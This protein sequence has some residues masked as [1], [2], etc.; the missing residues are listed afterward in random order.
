VFVQ[1]YAAVL[2]IDPAIERKIGQ[3]DHGSLTADQ[4]RQAVLLGAHTEAR[5]DD[6]P[7]HGE[8]WI[9]R[10]KSYDG[11]ELIAYVMPANQTD[12]GEFVLKTAIAKP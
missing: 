8:R 9:V 3:W 7:E 11:T 2:I 10:G 6:D 1:F 12:D 5:W 4:V